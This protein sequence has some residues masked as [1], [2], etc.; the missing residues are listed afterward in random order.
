MA[1]TVLRLISW[2]KR[3]KTNFDVAQQLDKYGN[4]TVRWFDSNIWDWLRV[5]DA[6]NIFDKQLNI[7]EI[8]DYLWKWYDDIKDNPDNPV[9]AINNF[10]RTLKKRTIR[11]S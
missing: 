6:Q 11:A 8:D 4:L 5:F 7:L 2:K 9:F 1:G 10:L 3:K